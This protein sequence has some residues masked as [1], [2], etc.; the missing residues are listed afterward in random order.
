MGID[1]G[2]EYGNGVGIV[3]GIKLGNGTFVGDSGGQGAVD[4][5]GLEDGGGV[6]E[7]IV[8]MVGGGSRGEL[9]NKIVAGCLIGAVADTQSAEGL[10]RPGTDSLIVHGG[11]GGIAGGLEFGTVVV[12]RFS[13]IDDGISVGLGDELGNNVGHGLRIG[14][15][16]RTG[17]LG[18]S[19]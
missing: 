12:G 6:G 4:G 11:V 15:R 8:V 1:D 2:I 7:G 13:R 18:S 10:G 16:G 5:I 19:I 14:F 9:N 17:E 3:G